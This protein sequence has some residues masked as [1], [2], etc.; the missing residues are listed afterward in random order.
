MENVLTS[1][2]T[3]LAGVGI[4]IGVSLIISGVFQIID[5]KREIF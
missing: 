3:V 1:I 4:G 5:G 2:C